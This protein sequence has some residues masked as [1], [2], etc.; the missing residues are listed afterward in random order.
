MTRAE[1]SQKRLSLAKLQKDHDRLKQLVLSLTS[2]SGLIKASNDTMNGG[3]YAMNSGYAMSQSS[4]DSDVSP[5]NGQMKK[6][7]VALKEVDIDTLI[8]EER[9]RDIRK[10]NQDIIMVNEMFQ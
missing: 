1:S 8:I 5:Q 6:T 10:I 3:G 9:E 7:L 4:G 2:E